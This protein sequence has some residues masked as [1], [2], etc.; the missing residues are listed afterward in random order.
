MNKKQVY[1]YFEWAFI[2]LIA[3]QWVMCVWTCVEDMLILREY[4]SVYSWAVTDYLINYQGGFV[5]RGMIGEVLYQLQVNYDVN[6]RYVMLGISAVS[7]VALTVLLIRAFYRRGIATYILPL[8]ICLGMAIT[9]RKD[10]LMLLLMWLIVYS[11]VN[12]KNNSTRLGVS[13]LAFTFLLNVHEAAFLFVWPILV[14]LIMADRK[15][16]N[17]QKW[18]GALLPLFVFAV[19]SFFKGDKEMAQAIHDSWI[20]YMPDRWSIYP[21]YSIKAIGWSTLPTFKMHLMTNY[22]KPFPECSW[23][24]G[25]MT[26]PVIYLAVYYLLC[27]YLLFFKRVSSSGEQRDTMIFSRIVLFQFIVLLP[28]FTIL[29]CDLGRVIFY[30]TVSSFV[31][32]LIVPMETLGRLMPVWYCEISDAIY[33]FVTRIVKPRKWLLCVIM[34]VITISPVLLELEVAIG[35]SVIGSIVMRIIG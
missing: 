30:W 31:I 24:Y 12:F 32:Y 16:G 8:A 23:L 15:L 3:Y 13:L 7:F 34:L 4:W 2:L 6:P 27:N 11:F 21:W 1:K 33:R 25:W 35:K 9:T 22:F 19:L 29:S 18:L 10:Y 17:V 14:L 26:R 5:R 28:L 20:P